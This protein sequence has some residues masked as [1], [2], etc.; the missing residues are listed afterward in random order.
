MLFKSK[1]LKE[2]ELEIPKHKIACI[3]KFL[4]ANINNPLECSVL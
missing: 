1:K 3:N 4:K 2:E